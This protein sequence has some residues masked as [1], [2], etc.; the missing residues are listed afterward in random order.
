MYEAVK[1]PGK[2][3]GFLWN[4]GLCTQTSE[5]QMQLFNIGWQHVP[6]F[7]QVL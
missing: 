2:E 3:G 1:E 5:E 4:S 6:V 7:Y